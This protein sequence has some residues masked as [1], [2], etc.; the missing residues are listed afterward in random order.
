MRI[1]HKFLKAILNPLRE[2]VIEAS[3]VIMEVYE[4]DSYDLDIKSDGSPVT[5]LMTLLLNLFTELRLKF[6]LFLKK[7]TRK[8]K[9]TQKA[10]I[11]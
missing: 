10:L 7:H 4:K 2:T 9:K 6:Q 8:N 11:G 5:E 3:K 1:T